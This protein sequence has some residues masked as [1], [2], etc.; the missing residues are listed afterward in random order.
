MYY[1]FNVEGVCLCSCN[2][3]PEINDL[4]E[5]G[6]CFIERAEHFDI[7]QICLIN[8]QIQEK[9]KASNDETD[10]EDADSSISSEILDM[11]EIVLGM[12]DTIKALQKGGETS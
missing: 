4:A 3:K 5:R 11:A 12:S 10:T 9:E 7:T 1:V 8:G 2:I 6:E